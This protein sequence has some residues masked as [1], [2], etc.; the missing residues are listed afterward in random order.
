MVKVEITEKPTP[1]GDDRFVNI[2]S[3]H[4]LKIMGFLIYRRKYFRIYQL[5]EMEEKKPIGFTKEKQ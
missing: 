3:D 4:T 2:E 5:E 1:V